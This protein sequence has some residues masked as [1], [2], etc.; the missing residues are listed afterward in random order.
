MFLGRS[1]WR[2]DFQLNDTQINEQNDT[3]LH[4]ITTQIWDI[5]H[6]IIKS[7]TTQDYEN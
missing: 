2:P 5:I 1:I 7:M 4:S 6:V 3:Q